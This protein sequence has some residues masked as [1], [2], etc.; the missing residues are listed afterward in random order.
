MRTI[1]KY[2]IS[3]GINPISMPKGAKVFSAN[4]DAN[5]R[6]SI[7]AAIR[8]EETETEDKLIYLTGTGWPLAEI[9]EEYTCRFIDTIVDREEEFV[10][11]VFELQE[12]SVY[13]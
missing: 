1:Y 9:G 8:T 10:W 2:H 12:R 6:L 3:N 4:L 11:H 7:W 5:G 13:D